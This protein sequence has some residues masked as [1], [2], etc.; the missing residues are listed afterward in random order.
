MSH[1][2]SILPVR[3]KYQRISVHVNK[4]TRNI[5]AASEARALG[6][7]GISWVPEATGIAR[8]TLHA[9]LNAWSNKKKRAPERIR[10]YGGGRKRGTDKAPKLLSDLEHIY[11]YKK[12]TS[13]PWEKPTI[14]SVYTKKKAWIRNDKNTGKAGGKKGNP[15]KVPGHDFPAPKSSK[16]AP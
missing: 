3:K 12:V 14:I 7:G 11:L 6:H 4:R 9:G 15:L 13:F 16:A 1:K 2:D 8:R 5:W 10:A